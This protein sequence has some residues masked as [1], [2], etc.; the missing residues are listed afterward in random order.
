MIEAAA[1]V[2]LGLLVAMS[3]NP[4]RRLEHSRQVQQVPGHER[5]IALRELVVEADA[6]AIVPGITVAGAGP[7]LADPARVRLRLRGVILEMHR[8]SICFVGLE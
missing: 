7:S 3:R 5:R 2:P 8:M 6:A 4:A 1:S